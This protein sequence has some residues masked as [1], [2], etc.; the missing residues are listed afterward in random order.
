ML[1]TGDAHAD[2]L[3]QSIGQLM[4]ERGKDGQKLKLDA[5]KLSHHGS[6]NATTIPLLQTLDCGRFLVS[7]HGN[8]FNHPDREA[9]ARVILHGGKAPTLCFNYKSTMNALW[10]ERI[11]Q[12]RYGYA[13][14]YPAADG[15]GLRIRL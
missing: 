8:L 7:T 10:G 2:V 5:I 12:E 14:E 11:L 9:I 4:R 3:I 15:A 6:G 13:T 1:L